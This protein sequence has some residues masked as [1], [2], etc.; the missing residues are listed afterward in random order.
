VIIEFES[1]GMLGTVTGMGIDRARL[2]AEVSA[3]GFELVTI[4]HWPR[5]N[6]YVAVFGKPSSVAQSQPRGGA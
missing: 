2:T 5:W 1:S 6:H 4:G 3:D